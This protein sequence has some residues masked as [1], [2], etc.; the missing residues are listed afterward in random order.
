MRREVIEENGEPV[1]KD[2]IDEVDESV[3]NRYKR[4]RQECLLDDLPLKPLEESENSEKR[5]VMHFVQSMT[6]TLKNK[7]YR[8][9][10]LIE[11]YLYNTP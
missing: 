11:D 3:L 7:L 9:F 1:I 4:H 6:S 8:C 10:G 5:D 2:F